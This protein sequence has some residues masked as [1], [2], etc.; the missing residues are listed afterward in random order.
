MNFLGTGIAHRLSVLCRQCHYGDIL[1]IA[2]S[3]G[4]IMKK[5]LTL[6]VS[7]L[8]LTS[9]V[10]ITGRLDVKEDMKVKKKSGFLNL[11]RKTETL[12]AGLYTAT[13]SALGDKN[14]NLKL[15]GRDN[16]K[17]PLKTEKEIALP[18]TNGAI[19]VSGK[20][21]DQPFDVAGTIYTNVERSDSRE[22]TES[23]T[24]T[25]T[26][27]RCEKVCTV[28]NNVRTC[29]V[30]CTPVT[31]SRSGYRFVLYHI[32]TTYRDLKLQLLEQNSDK[33]LATF[34]GDDVETERV[35]ERTGICR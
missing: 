16:F 12:P 22:T 25:T 1:A 32:K 14:F 10:D 4:G 19:K 13:V 28:T 11:K 20:D 5:A 18:T 35:V 34:V 8:V 29:D 15:E 2:F 24:W 6:L 7:V 31:I 26:E 9:C 21:L 17:I 27:E 33:L 3:R 23:C 30:Q